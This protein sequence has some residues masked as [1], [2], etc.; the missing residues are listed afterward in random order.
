MRHRESTLLQRYHFPPIVAR[1]RTLGNLLNWFV[2]LPTSNPEWK[3]YLNLNDLDE[4]TPTKMSIWKPAEAPPTKLG[5]YRA[6][7]ST[8]G[9]HVSPLCL[10]AMV[11]I[12]EYTRCTKYTDSSSVDWRQVGSAWNGVDE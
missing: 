4:S 8:A 1:D 11:S 7:S 3:E 9:V 5:R 12:F 6:L 2:R 10:G